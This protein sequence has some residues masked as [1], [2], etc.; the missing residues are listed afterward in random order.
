M[1]NFLNILV[2]E[3]NEIATTTT[4]PLTTVCK[5]GDTP[6]RTIIL[7]ITIII[8]TPIRA[9]AGLPV[10]NLLPFSLI[11]PSLFFHRKILFFLPASVYRFFPLP[12]HLFHLEL[13]HLSS[14][15]P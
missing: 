12:L 10:P 15:L 8:P 1:I 4:I 14:C 11:L 2:I 6:K 9:P 13:L 5:Y 7:W 3:S